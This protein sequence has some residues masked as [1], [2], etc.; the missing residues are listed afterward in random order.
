[1]DSIRTAGRQAELRNRFL[2]SPR[3][4][5]YPDHV[6]LVTTG[7]AM[8]DD[9]TEIK[10][11]VT[12]PRAINIKK[13][14]AELCNWLKMS[15]PPLGEEWVCDVD[16][17]PHFEHGET[18]VVVTINEAD[19]FG[20]V[21]VQ[22]V[23]D[24]TRI[25]LSPSAR[26]HGLEIVTL[27][28]RQRFMPLDIKYDERSST[29]EL[30]LPPQIELIKPKRASVPHHEDIEVRGRRFLELA[31]QIALDP[32]ELEHVSTSLRSGI[33]AVWAKFN[34]RQGFPR[35]HQIN[36]VMRTIA[37]VVGR[38]ARYTGGFFTELV[39]QPAYHYVNPDDG[40]DYGFDRYEEY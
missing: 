35:E 33:P 24:A 28:G 39:A 12:A 8:G 23:L 34:I 13:V 14:R 3:L 25:F 11:M 36:K 7:D 17:Q 18:L 31:L 1:M 21:S 22:R 20:N 16:L 2:L 5:E 9:S 19:R 10:L 32:F 15:L 37:Q 4:V 29:I 38:H 27:R 40:G 6:F 26:T 30:E